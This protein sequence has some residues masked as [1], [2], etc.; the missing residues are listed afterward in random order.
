M[1]TSKLRQDAEAIWKAGV[2]AVDSGR[3]VRRAVR[4]E[5]AS[6]SGRRWLA[7]DRER[8]DVSN[9]GRIAVVGAGKAGA[10]MAAALEEILSAAGLLDR[11]TGWI[12]VPA[13]CVRPLRKI[14]LHAAR[15]AGVNEPTDEGVRGAERILE[16]VSGL[17][18]RDLCIVI[19]SGGGSALL[20]APVP[21]ITLE[22]KRAVTRFLMSNGA[23]I[24]EL[25]TVRKQLSRIKGGGLA[26]ASHAGSTIALIISDIIGDPLDMIAS[27]PTVVESTRPGD[28]LAVLKGFARDR[29]AIPARVWNYLEHASSTASD[30]TPHHP[31]SVRNIV[32]GNNQVAIEAAADCARKLGYA[33]ES[34]GSLN[35]GEARDVGRDLALRSRKIRNTRPTDQ[36]PVCILSGGE[37][38]VHL[39]KSGKPRKGGRNQE[40][41]LAALIELWP[42]GI[43]RIAILSGGTDGE[44]GPTDAAGAVIDTDVFQIARGRQLDPA[45]FLS[46]NNAYPFFDETGGLLKTGPTHTN[47]MDLRV[48]LIGGS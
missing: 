42:D 26:R 20:P 9:V 25:N 46:I 33:V 13:D 32:I 39:A 28:A 27:G 14:H 45:S 31:A 36:Q 7:I 47:V 29:N 19:I 48:A 38:V 30:E 23:T 5:P 18:A 35:E 2:D 44:D 17:D 41:A 43:E 11:V 37:P 34:L 40:L 3:L 1:T 8:Y 12:N 21:E 15:P 6:E 16:I 24:R 4:L 22:D 10:G